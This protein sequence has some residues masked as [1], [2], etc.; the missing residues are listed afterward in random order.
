MQN[1][2]HAAAQQAWGEAQEGR[3]QQTFA[4]ARPRSR[5]RQARITVAPRSAS[6]SENAAPMPAFA[7]VTMHVCEVQRACRCQAQ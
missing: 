2:E 6:A 1:E 7:P 5:E 4:A 3:V